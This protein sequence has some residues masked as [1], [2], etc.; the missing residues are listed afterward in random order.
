M[1][2]KVLYPHFRASDKTLLKYNSIDLS[3]TPKERELGLALIG[4]TFSVTQSLETIFQFQQQVQQDQT[5]EQN[6]QIQQNQVLCLISTDSEMEQVLLVARRIMKE[7]L[8][9]STKAFEARMKKAQAERQIKLKQAAAQAT[10]KESEIKSEEK[11]LLM[12][13]KKTS[14]SSNP[15]VPS[16]DQKK[17][18]TETETTED[19]SDAV[20]NRTASIDSEESEVPLGSNSN[21]NV[22]THDHVTQASI[23]KAKTQEAIEASDSGAVHV[24]IRSN[25]SEDNHRPIHDHVNDQSKEDPELSSQL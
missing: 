7:A 21:S 13:D 10:A 15:A 18:E 1:Y 2:L 8:D 6:Q 9:A 19:H 5:R 24:N 20:I 11:T 12:S 23:V 25:T 17:M 16:S 22:V 4:L 14:N 3:R